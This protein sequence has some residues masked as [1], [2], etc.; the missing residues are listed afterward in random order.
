[1]TVTPPSVDG[2]RAYPRAG[3]P[4]RRPELVRYGSALLSAILPGLGHLAVGRIRRAGFF[5]L[6]V[7][8]LVGLLLMWI[9]GQPM[10]R[11]AAY[12]A[13]P[14]VL[15][16]LLVVQA[17]ILAWR[18]TAVALVL[19]D[20]RFP[21]LG[22]RDALPVMLLVAIVILPQAGMG[23][24]TAVAQ[25]AAAQVFQPSTADAGAPF[26]TFGDE[27]PSP[28]ASLDPSPTAGPQRLTV[29]LLGVDAGPNRNTAS[30][31]T[32]IVASLDPVAKTVSMISVPRDLVNVPLAR[33]GV[34]RP[35]V[36]GLVS[37]VRWHPDEFPG[38]KGNGQ[39]VL[40]G[41]LGKLLG[42]RID[43]YAQ[44]N[45]PGF[46]Q[47]VN[48]VGGIT[49][50]V[51]HGLCDAAY[52]EYGYEGSHF[53]IGAGRHK[54][55]G[56][57]ALAYARIRKSLGESDF[58][59]A[60][61]QQQVL[62]ALRDRIV[63]GGFLDDP[64]GLL[65]ALGNTVETNVPPK[66]LPDLAPLVTQISRKSVFQTVIKSPLVHPSYD[67]RGSIQIPDLARIKALG[68]QL[69]PAPGTP[70]K[71]TY[72]A[73]APTKIASGPAAAAPSCYAPRPTAKPTPK[74]TAKPTAKPSSAPSPTPVQSSAPSPTP[75]DKPKDTATPS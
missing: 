70:V 12:L 42:I 43:Y 8:L 44:V 55:N 46:V 31:D 73:P 23:Y 32:M 66:L 33:G 37:Y 74:P 14:D 64:V 13:D 54:L 62:V 56:N 30:T 4:A 2:P 51:D 6:P 22:R 59:R 9:A 45:L 67:A 16:A 18:L 60:S 40:A 48:A 28:G 19:A 7:I 41:A 69:F 39:A 26:P 5:L 50:D 11:S 36:N 34:F 75:T 58:T 63:R 15:G 10:I 1:M 38:Y 52:D 68:K 24:L 20:G 35:K 25:T 21:R 29:L 53:A 61:R 57:A 47:V 49:V 17:G 27:S 72:L 3:A 65:R 71:V